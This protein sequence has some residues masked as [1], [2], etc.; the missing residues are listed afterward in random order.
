MRTLRVAV[1]VCAVIALL[2]PAALAQ[3]PLPKP[4]PEH[5][6]LK[7][8]EGTWEATIKT[9]EG[10]SKGTMVYKMDLGGLWLV[11]NFTADFGGMKFKGKGIDGYDPAKKK[12][13]SV[14]VDSMTPTLMIFEGN[15]DKEGKVFKQFGEGPGMDGKLTK[16]KSVT[17]MK[18]DDSMVFTMSS[19]DNEGKDQ[20]MLTIMYKRKK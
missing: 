14:W 13:V 17:E 20:T 18:D 3:P 15:F 6:H 19:K 9:P 4:G 2:A 5:E 1:V 12:Y 11:S 7:K 10:E 16:L 8:M